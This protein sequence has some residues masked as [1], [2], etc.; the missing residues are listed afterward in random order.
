[1]A[2]CPAGRALGE[3]HAPA[4]P[5]YSALASWERSADWLNV[6]DSA[7]PFRM[8]FRPLDHDYQLPEWALSPLQV[9]IFTLATFLLGAGSILWL[10]R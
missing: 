3:R 5:T 6:S 10:V 8:D 4:G 9:F 2:T 1:M 7:E